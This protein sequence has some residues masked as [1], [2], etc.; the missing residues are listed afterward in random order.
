MVCIRLY[1]H[2]EQPFQQKH[3]SK[4]RGSPRAPV[5]IREYL[6]QPHSINIYPSKNQ[7]NSEP[8][9]YRIYNRVPFGSAPE[10]NEFGSIGDLF[11]APFSSNLPELLQHGQSNGLLP[12][13]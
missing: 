6:E 13:E 1:G 7:I 4:R 5:K 3:Q 12:K 2:V 9:F 8:D 11:H 10:N